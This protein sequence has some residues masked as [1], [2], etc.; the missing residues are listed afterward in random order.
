M[1]YN[2]SLTI[3]ALAF[4]WAPWTLVMAGILKKEKIRN[5]LGSNRPS[6]YYV[7]RIHHEI[8]RMWS[9]EIYKKTTLTETSWS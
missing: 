5:S 8:Y 1:S 7:C 3:A 2:L 6:N 9:R 4:R